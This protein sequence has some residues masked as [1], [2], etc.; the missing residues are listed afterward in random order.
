LGADYVR[1]CDQF[2]YRV[3]YLEPGVYFHKVK[4][5]PF[6]K[7]FDGSG[8]G[9]RF[10]SA[11]YQGCAVPPFYDSMVAKLI[12][13]DATRARA[14]ARMS[15]AL[16]E[17]VIEGIATNRDQQKRIIADPQFRSGQFGT[18]YYEELAGNTERAP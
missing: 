1:T 17:L 3:F 7:E 12:V 2:A 4:V 10:D 6:H 5:F 16:D 15:R 13:H 14:A 9:V 18:R 8:P 11:L